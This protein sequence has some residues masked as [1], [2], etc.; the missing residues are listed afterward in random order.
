MGSREHH[1]RKRL[2]PGASTSL[3]FRTVFKRHA[4][5]FVLWIKVFGF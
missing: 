2:L 4:P 5:D 3:S 1:V